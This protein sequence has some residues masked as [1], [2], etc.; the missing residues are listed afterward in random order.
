MP[1]SDQLKVNKRHIGK[2]K[3]SYREKK[4]LFTIWIHIVTL[5]IEMA[6]TPDFFLNISY[7]RAKPRFHITVYQLVAYYIL[8]YWKYILYKPINMHHT[9]TICPMHIPSYILQLCTQN[10]GSYL[11]YQYT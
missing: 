6:I 7:C 10:F 8:L 5:L 3:L 4:K 9:I 11:S 2:I 1:P